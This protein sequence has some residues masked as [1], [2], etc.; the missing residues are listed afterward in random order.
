MAQKRGPFTTTLWHEGAGSLLIPADCVLKSLVVVVTDSGAASD[1]VCEVSTAPDYGTAVIFK[2]AALAGLVLTEPMQFSIYDL[3]VP[4]S[5]GQQLFI[6][7]EGG[8]FTVNA[9]LEL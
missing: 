1:V 5:Q 2:I 6:N 3:R 9:V 8:G 7:S 4:L